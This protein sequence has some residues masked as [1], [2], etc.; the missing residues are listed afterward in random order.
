[1]WPRYLIP[2]QAHAGGHAHIRPEYARYFEKTTAG[3]LLDAF[4]PYAPFPS[5]VTCNR[6]LEPDR[7][8]V[9]LAMA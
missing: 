1:M 3:I 6:E 4:E 2:P 8:D 5:V 7:P 9:F